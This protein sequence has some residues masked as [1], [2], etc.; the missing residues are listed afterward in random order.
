MG[1]GDLAPA[2]PPPAHS[3]LRPRPSALPGLQPGGQR[4]GPHGPPPPGPPAPSGEGAPRGLREGQPRGRVRKGGA[5]LHSAI[6]KKKKKKKAQGCATGTR[7][8]PSSSSSCSGGNTLHH[9]RP[10]PPGA[11]YASLAA[12]RTYPLT[13]AFAAGSRSCLQGVPVSESR[14][15]CSLVEINGPS[16]LAFKSEQSRHPKASRGRA[17]QVRASLITL[18]G[19]AVQRGSLGPHLP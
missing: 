18:T 19:T 7:S 3:P 17:A 2:A 16:H 1:W 8:K 14:L 9:E 4:L 11:G 12:A 5:S 15:R 13:P 10:P 6:Y